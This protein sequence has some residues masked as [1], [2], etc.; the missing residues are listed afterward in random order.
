MEQSSQVTAGIRDLI[1]FLHRGNGRQAETIVA[2]VAG[3]LK[4]IMHSGMDPASFPM[5][6]AQQTMFAIVEVQ[7][8]LA[9]ED[10]EGAAEA[11]RDAG[12]EWKQKPVAEPATGQEK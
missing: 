9:Q 3:R 5:Q 6:R 10:F 12:K 7:T 8:L 11:A 4:V 1:V 2:D